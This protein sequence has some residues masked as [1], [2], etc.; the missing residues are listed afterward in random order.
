MS[1]PGFIALVV[2]LFLLLTPFFVLSFFIATT[3]NLDLRRKKALAL[4]TALAISIICIVLFLFGELIFR[5]LGITLD[6]FRLGCGLVL[7]LTGIDLVRDSGTPK[8]RECEPCDDPAVVPL[9]IPCT[10]GPGTI[11]TLLVM[12]SEVASPQMRLFDC[13]AIFLRVFRR[14]PCSFFR[15]RRDTDP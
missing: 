12:G 8:A 7:L 14:G 1:V 11:G 9:A 3:S 2:K 5:Y 13:G 4:R 10:V 6:A 15:R